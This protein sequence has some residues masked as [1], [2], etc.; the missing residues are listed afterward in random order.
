MSHLN[1]SLQGK[2]STVVHMLEDVFGGQDDTV[3]PRCTGEVCSLTPPLLK[4]SK[5]STITE[6]VIIGRVMQAAFGERFI[7]LRKERNALSF[8]VKVLDMKPS[9][10]NFST[11]TG[12]SQP[13][14]EMK[15]AHKADK[16]L[17]VSKLK[18]LA[19]DLKE[20]VRHKTTLAKKPKLAFE[21]WNAIPDIDVNMKSFIWSP[22]HV[23]LNM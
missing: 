13:H 10:Q 18:S 19:A 3:C 20:A 21:T 4:R 2:R 8:S 15:L 6:I 5:K 1:T 11:F 16:D 12:V 22:V 14:L 23:W 7:E 17:W 9:L